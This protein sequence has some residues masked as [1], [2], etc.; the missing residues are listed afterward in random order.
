MTE[1]K[2]KWNQ[3]INYDLKLRHKPGNMMDTNLCLTSWPA[4]NDP[5]GL[6]HQLRMNALKIYRNR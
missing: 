3:G 6:V 4:Q 2:E 5:K 1:M